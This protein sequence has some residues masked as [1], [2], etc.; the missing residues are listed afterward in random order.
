VE[1]PPPS[2]LP[3]EADDPLGPFRPPSRLEPEFHAP[4]PRPIPDNLRQGRYE[5]TRRVTLFFGGLFAAS[6]LG[7]WIATRGT[8]LDRY[9]LALPYFHL[10]AAVVALLTVAAAIFQ[11]AFPGR[12]AYV[13]NGIPM[14][15]RIRDVRLV[16]SATAN[17]A[18]SAYRYLCTVEYQPP[19]ADRPQFAVLPSPDFSEMFK[20][21]TDT[22]L[23]IGDYVTAVALPGRI[24]Q[25]LTLYGFLQLNPDVDFVQRK[26]G[27][28]RRL[29]PA[30]QAFLFVSLVYAFIGL[31]LAVICLPSFLGI[32]LP[33][34]V[35]PPWIAAAGFAALVGMVLTWRW[36]QATDQRK[37]A[38]LDR[39]NE[40]ARAEGRPVEEFAPVVS[41]SPFRVLLVIAGGFVPVMLGSLAVAT[42]N[43]LFDPAPP[44]F[45]LVRITDVRHQT[46]LGVFR[47]YEVRCVTGAGKTETIGVPFTQIARFQA[48]NTREGALERKPGYLRMPWIRDVHPVSQ[49]VVGTRQAHLANGSVVNVGP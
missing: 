19:G 7:V 12:Y 3:D 4:E 42:V 26:G 49:T 40:M 16:V 23:R 15:C 30:V 29:S 1:P 46:R 6:A 34:S 36:T 41:G 35:P 27:E 11:A 13:R 10:V 31:L 43:A 2:V 8:D 39:Q 38:E 14:P 28:A 21:G 24:Q 45:E 5:H 22:P 33:D 44:V 37:R 48:L 20:K 25:T 17:G 18:P 9:F 32:G 47:S